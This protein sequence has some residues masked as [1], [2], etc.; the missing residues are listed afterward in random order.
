[1][2]KFG[3]II[4]LSI[5]AIVIVVGFFTWADWKTKIIQKE[6]NQTM[7]SS[8]TASPNYMITTSIVSH[9]NDRVVYAEISDC[10]KYDQ[11]C[12]WKYA[13]FVKNLSTGALNKIYS[14][15]EPISFLQSVTSKFVKAAVAGGCPLVPFPIAWSKNDKKIILEWGNPTGCGSGGVPKYLTYTLDSNGGQLNNLSTYDP[16]FLDD[17]QKVI[18]IDESQKSPDKCGPVSQNNH[19]KIVLQHI[20]TGEIRILREEPNSDYSLL[21]TDLDQNLLKYSVR[22]VQIVNDCSEIDMSIEEKTEEIMIP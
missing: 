10:L 3:K 21:S 11:V 16:I 18:F 17:Y 13:I 7:K 22:K 5:I 6:I 8:V 9:K 15:P 4:M 20:E 2:T 12:D 19:G 14:Y 1:M